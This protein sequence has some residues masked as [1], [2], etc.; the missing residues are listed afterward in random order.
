MGDLE[1]LALRLAQV[2]NDERCEWQ[3]HYEAP[4]YG[5]P[6][7]WRVNLTWVDEYAFIHGADFVTFD[8]MTYGDTAARALLAA[9]EWAEAL[10]TWGQAAESQSA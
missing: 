8:W 7:S 9:V 1:S 10:H 6:P 3:M 4:M 5:N 2:W